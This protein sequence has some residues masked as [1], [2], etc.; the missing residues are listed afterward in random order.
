MSTPTPNSPTETNSPT[1]NKRVGLIFA[2]V[3][4]LAVVAVVV[5]V[6]ISTSGKKTPRSDRDQVA[7]ASGTFI[8]ALVA[9]DTTRAVSVVCD[10]DKKDVKDS[11]ASLGPKSAETDSLIKASMIS[12]SQVTVSGSVARAKTQFETTY[13]RKVGGTWLICPSAEAEFPK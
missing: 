3:A 4:L 1:S 5:V 2:A 10:A 8:A 12:A 11:I 7:A 6:V 13:F 9:R